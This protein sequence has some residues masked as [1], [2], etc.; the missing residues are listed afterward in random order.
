MHS[1]PALWITR[2]LSDKTIARAFRDYNVVLDAD[3]VPADS[4]TII[5][6][7]HEVDAI[8]P[9]HS[10]IFDQAVVD[11]LSDRVKIIANHSVGVDHCD[12]NALRSR[13]IVVTNTPDV[14]SDATA[15]IA[16][17]LLLGAA[18]HAVEGDS[19][20]RSGSWSSWNCWHGQSRTGHGQ[21]MPWL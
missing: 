21:A 18:R 17:L 20:M 2:K 9:C 8:I 14:L 19:L 15:E 11:Q 10:E 3:D 12:L 1:K 16:M 4:D 6:R 5:A 7:S 13:G